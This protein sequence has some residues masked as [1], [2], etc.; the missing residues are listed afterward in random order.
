M[1][2]TVL[3]CGSEV[4]TTGPA[5]ENELSASD[6]KR[7]TEKPSDKSARGRNVRAESLRG[8]TRRETFRV[9]CNLKVHYHNVHSRAHH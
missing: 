5:G 8:S 9:L 1:A 3:T 6:M 2:R 4:R 7:E